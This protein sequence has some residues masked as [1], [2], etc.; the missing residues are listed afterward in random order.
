ML[1]PAERYSH[2]VLMLCVFDRPRSLSRGRRSREAQGSEVR[3][4]QC[5]GLVHDTKPRHV[6]PVL[7]WLE[8]VWS[9]APRPVTHQPLGSG[10]NPF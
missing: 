3:G 1:S 5:L 8:D 9:V 7:Q 4:V 2:R 6:P 10:L